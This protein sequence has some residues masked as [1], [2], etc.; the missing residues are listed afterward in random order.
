M[1]MHSSYYGA[2]TPA[3]NGIVYFAGGVILISLLVS[4]MAC[5]MMMP[6]KRCWDI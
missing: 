1:P 3:S 6:L 4:L 5:K 2:V